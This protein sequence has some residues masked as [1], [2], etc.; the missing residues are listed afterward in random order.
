[1]LISFFSKSYIPQYVL[2]V[3]LTLAMLLPGLW[4]EPGLIANSQEYTSPGWALIMG[5]TQDIPVLLFIFQ[6]ILLFMGGIFLNYTLEKYDLIP[7]NSLIAAFLYILLSCHSPQF[8]VLSPGIFTASLVIIIIFLLFDIYSREEP[9]DR[10]FYIG[11]I[12]AIAAF[13]DFIQVLLLLAIIFSFIIFRIFKWREWLI[14]LFGFITPM[15]LL[16]VY[17]FLTDQLL[18]SRFIKTGVG[19]VERINEIYTHYSLTDYIILTIVIGLFILGAIKLTFSVNDKLIS[20]R[21]RYWAVFWFFII[22]LIEYFSGGYYGSNNAG[23]I[24]IGM[25]II[26][27][28]FYTSL[29]RLFWVELINLFVFLLILFNIYFTLFMDNI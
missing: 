14:L 20:I 22:F 18:I 16:S 4:L 6:F 21:K 13:F 19:S 5:L 10:I 1:M 23:L 28:F 25:V 15:V 2:L 29:K 8:L 9:Y 26:I 11:F 27:S 12:I 7:K 24:I 17:F 3:V